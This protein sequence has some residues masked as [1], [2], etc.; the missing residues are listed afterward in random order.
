M[1]SFRATYEIE[2]IQDRAGVPA[3][4]RWRPSFWE[5]ARLDLHRRYILS[6][7]PHGDRT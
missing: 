2:A 5:A 3:A 6:R 1:A 4:D 7:L